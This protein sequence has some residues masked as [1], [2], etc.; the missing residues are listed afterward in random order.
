MPE[1]GYGLALDTAARLAASLDVRLDLVGRWPS[2]DA[3][4]AFAGAS[5]I[6]G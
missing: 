3:E 4:S 2:A 1:K 5:R 6:S